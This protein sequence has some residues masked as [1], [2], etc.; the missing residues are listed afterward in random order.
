[1]Q[2]NSGVCLWLKKTPRETVMKPNRPCQKIVGR[3][4]IYPDGR[5]LRFVVSQRENLHTI[6]RWFQVDS[7]FSDP[8]FASHCGRRRSR[9]GGGKKMNEIWRKEG[10]RLRKHRSHRWVIVKCMRTAFVGSSS[11]CYVARTR[12]HHAFVGNG[13]FIECCL[14]REKGR[15][16][17]GMGGGIGLSGV[18]ECGKKQENE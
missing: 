11:V 13:R 15:R 18:S 12:S 14:S 4:I 10:K 17:A 3:R 2:V 5:S 1:V 8:E 7:S 9:R 6:S 16:D